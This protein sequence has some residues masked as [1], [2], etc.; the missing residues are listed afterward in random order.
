[1]VICGTLDSTCTLTPRDKGSG[2]KI[3]EGGSLMALPYEVNFTVADGAS[4]VGKKRKYHGSFY[5]DST[6]TVANALTEAA[7]L[8]QAI[9]NDCVGQIESAR[10]ILPVD[11]SG[12]TSNGAPDPQSNGR[13]RHVFSMKSAEGHDAALRIPAADQSNSIDN[14]EN[15][16]ITTALSAGK[17]IADQLIS[18]PIVTSH[19]EPITVVTGATEFWG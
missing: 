7:G 19:D 15:V 12:L 13:Y 16:D 18:R 4:T 11:I 10:L 2:A 17:V 9:A 5:I 1:M 14:S 6:T 3:D 8:L